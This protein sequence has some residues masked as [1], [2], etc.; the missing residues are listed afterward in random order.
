MQFLSRS[1]SVSNERFRAVLADLR[2]KDL[3]LLVDMYLL[4]LDLE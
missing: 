4:R 3:E 2:A 1:P